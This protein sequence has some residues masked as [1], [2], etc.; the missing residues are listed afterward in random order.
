MTYTAIGEV[1]LSQA[2][3]DQLL[4]VEIGV[5]SDTT[6]AITVKIFTNGDLTTAKDTRTITPTATRQHLPTQRPNVRSAK[7]HQISISQA[8]GTGDAGVDFVRVKGVS[9]N[10]V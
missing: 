2:E 7:S 6:N 3:A 10:V 8:C 1:H 4:R 5:R 9:S